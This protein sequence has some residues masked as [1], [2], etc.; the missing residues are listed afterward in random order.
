MLVRA[1][2]KV[3]TASALSARGFAECHSP[4]EFRISVHDSF[5][6]VFEMDVIDAGVI[7]TIVL[8]LA[9]AN[10]EEPRN[11]STCFAIS[12]VWRRFLSGRVMS[13]AIASPFAPRTNEMYAETVSFWFLVMISSLMASG[14]L[15]DCISLSER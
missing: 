14:V 8:S 6:E 15:A 12:A 7:A 13:I 1:E 2:T 4:T 9:D 10:H 5:A 11:P 3:L